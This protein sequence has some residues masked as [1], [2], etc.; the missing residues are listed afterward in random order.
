MPK[1]HLL[2]AGHSGK[3]LG[4]SNISAMLCN[5]V[6]HSQGSVLLCWSVTLDGAVLSSFD[7][8]LA[9]YALK[10]LRQQDCDVRLEE[11]VKEV[12]V[13]SYMCCS[14]VYSFA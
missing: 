1:I 11:S 2:E 6:I 12:R 13:P 8:Q 4:T 10:Q 14:K 9:D 3:C 7:N 5:R